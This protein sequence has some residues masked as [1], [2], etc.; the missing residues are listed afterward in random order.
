M[1]KIFLT[2]ERNEECIPYASASAIAE[3]KKYNVP[4]N[5]TSNA[6]TAL[7]SL[8]TNANGAVVFPKGV[9]VLNSSLTVDTSKVKAIYGN[10]AI[11]K[12]TGDFPALIVQGNPTTSDWTAGPESMNAKQ[13]EEDSCTVISGLKITSS[14][15]S[16]GIGIVL[17]NTFTAVVRDCYIFA[18][19]IGIEVRGRNRNII[20]EGNNIYQNASYGIIYS[21]GSNVHQTNIVGNHISYQ[22]FCIYFKETDQ[23]ANVQIT[24]N[25]IEI[26]TWPSGSLTSS[27]CVVIDY[28]NDTSP[29]FSEFEFVGNTIQGHELSDGLID[30]MSDNISHPIENVSIVGNQI[31]NVKSGGYAVKLKNCHNIAISGNTYRRVTNGAIFKLEGTVDCLAVSGETA[32]MGATYVATDSAAILNYVTLSGLNGKSLTKGINI[33]CATI[34]GLVINGCNLTGG[35]TVAATTVDYVSVT[36]NISRGTYSIATCSHR[37][38]ENNI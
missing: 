18:I 26:S 21:E 37:A 6:A 32:E 13:K 5:G 24:G 33:N 8:L 35:M 34:N 23:T 25:D 27:R 20:I 2:N 12:V 30:I 36:G 19:K 9:Y 14:N 31:S 7:Q 11:L 17:T 1:N 29:L 4:T 16:N 22:Q 10:G 15:S 38:V 3:F 28:Q